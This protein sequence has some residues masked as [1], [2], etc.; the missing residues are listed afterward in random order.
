MK[1]I[2][3]AIVA[4]LASLGAVSGVVALRERDSILAREAKEAAAKHPS[5]G[6]PAA[7]V[8]PAPDPIPVEAEAHTEDLSASDPPETLDPIP[9]TKDE[10]PA[11][12]AAVATTAD[13]RETSTTPPDLT[14]RSWMIRCAVVG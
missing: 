12:E 3:I 14:E 7:T 13:N 10:A 1:S 6:R 11:T 9:E 5:P 2:L 4:F 8:A